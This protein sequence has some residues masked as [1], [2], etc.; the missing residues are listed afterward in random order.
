MPV[1][2]I[3]VKM[4]DHAFLMNQLDLFVVIV[5]LD[6]Q[7]V[8][9]I[10]VSFFS[11]SCYEHF[12]TMNMCMLMILGSAVTI[13][14]PN[15]C[16]PNPCRNGGS[17]QANSIGGF[18]CLCPVG[19]QG[20]CCEIRKWYIQSTFFS[21]QMTQNLFYVFIGSDPCQPNPCQ[22]NGICIASGTST[23]C[24]CLTGFSGQRC[25]IRKYSSLTDVD[26]IF[27]GWY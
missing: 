15:P 2:R 10:S 14:P 5:H 26:K 17:C 18:M 23:V 19:F 11:Y 7:V 6:I 21:R 24:S 8:R 16:S 13:A 4:E 27:C 3:H 1:F 9:V 22:N 25:E 12:T 20:I